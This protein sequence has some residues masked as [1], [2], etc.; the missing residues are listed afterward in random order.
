MSQRNVFV[1]LGV[2]QHCDT[3]ETGTTLGLQLLSVTEEQ[4]VA[5]ARTVSLPAL[6]AA[7]TMSATLS[8]M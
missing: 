6:A 5:L 7:V 2:V 4:Q 1:L 8:T 3:G